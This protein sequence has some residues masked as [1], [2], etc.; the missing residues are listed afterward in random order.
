MALLV[1][2]LPFAG[3]VPV[4]DEESYLFIADAVIEHPGRP[5][6]WWR[7]WQPW[8]SEPAEHSFLFAHP[9]LH[10]WWV[11]FWKAL[12]GAGW[13]WRLGVTLLPAVLLGVSV[14]RLAQHVSRRPSTAV[15]PW[16]C[17]PVVVMA[18]C[19]GGLP[20]LAVTALATAAVAAWRE[21]QV[22]RDRVDARWMGA[23]GVLLGLAACW[24]YP[25]LV[26][27]PVL[28]G[29]AWRRGIVKQALP[30]ALGFAAV[31][32]S[33]EAWL[34]LVY[35][36]VHL[37]EVLATAPDIA[38]G[39][40]FGR[41]Y[42]VLTRLGLALSPLLLIVAT[43]WW[44]IGVGGLVLSVL[45]ALVLVGPSELT[46]GGVAIL[47]VLGAAGTVWVVRAVIGVLPA[48]SARRRK[49]DRDDGFLLG[50]WAL[51]VL[52]GVW[53]GH[54]YAGGR[55]LLPAIAPLALLISRTAE[56]LPGGKNRL[57][58]A[59]AAWGLVA[60]VLA[61]TETRYGSAAEQAAERAIAAHPIGRFS[62]EWAFRYT[63]EQAGWTVVTPDETLE[64][65]TLVAVP[66]NGGG[67]VGEGWQAVETYEADDPWKVRVVELE[68]GVGYHAE[69]LGPLPVGWSNGPLE[70]VTVYRVGP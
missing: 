20:D 29:H 37:L 49:N 28:A 39:P 22:D 6:D 53:F 25:A 10:L 13:G 19:A 32:G 61:D 50:A 17:S 64:T 24:K 23:A 42:G 33:L 68:E 34:A 44:R 69:T 46:S 52:L 58:V 2:A 63:M 1:A 16:L 7:A 66:R 15:M 55:Y 65:G 26:L 38:R 31:W 21:A 5:Y 70:A 51:A 3:D 43:L 8:G 18:V 47:G 36:Q 45:L 48:D 57:R 41:G 14:G 4:L 60:V 35:G 11:A 40:F 67:F 9:P 27:V 30:A 59:A 62:G 56:N 54:N 12:T